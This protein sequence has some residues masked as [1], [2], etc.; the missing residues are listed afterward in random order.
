MK[1]TQIIHSKPSIS[2]YDSKS[3]LHAIDSG[4]V[5]QGKQVE[6][7]NNYFSTLFKKET[8]FFVNSGTSAFFLALKGLGIKE[9][10]EVI[11]SNYLCGSI[12]AQVALLKAIP[13]IIDTIEGSFFVSVETI[14]RTITPKTKA[15]VINH[16]FG[17]FELAVLELKNLGIPIIEDVTHSLYAKHDSIV[18]GT[19]ADITIA[20][21]GSTK[22]ITSGTGGIISLSNKSWAI[23]V[24]RFLDHDYNK[25]PASE[26]EIR[27]NY[28][29]GDVNAA[30]LQG[31]FEQIESFIKKRVELARNYYS[32]LTLPIYP[33][34]FNEGSVYFRFFVQVKKEKANSIREKLEENNIDSAQGAVSLLNKTFSLTQLFPNAEK[35]WS[36]LISIPIYPGIKPKELNRIVK[37]LNAFQ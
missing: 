24:E 17:H 26:G 27:F 25:F 36:E 19:T 8:S 34:K 37:V 13:K 15:I 20:S 22:F 21:F 5:G 12:Y 33:A 32:K 4:F 30:L 28:K 2:K 6:K 18:A 14:I 10:D 7:V 16:P 35:I 1:T 11:L 3:V 31:Q 23:E 29:L 9:N